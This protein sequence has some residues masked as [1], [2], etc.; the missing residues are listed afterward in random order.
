MSR[1]QRWHSRDLVVGP[2]GNDLEVEAACAGGLDDPGVLDQPPLGQTL[3]EALAEPGHVA[4]GNR[5]GV[6][7]DDG[8]AVAAESFRPRSAALHQRRADALGAPPQ[9]EVRYFRAAD[10]EHHR[11]GLAEVLVQLRPERFAGDQR[12]IGHRVQPGLQVLPDLLGILDRVE[13]LHEHDR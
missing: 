11:H 9:F 1:S 6:N 10:R 2:A 7:E 4:S 5:V 13:Q 8:E 12:K 3:H